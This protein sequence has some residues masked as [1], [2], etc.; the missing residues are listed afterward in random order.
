[1]ND[2][3][4]C[5]RDIPKEKWRYGLRSSAATGCGWIAVYNA[6]RLMGYNA[7]PERLIQHFENM[8]PLI[9]GNMGTF[10]LAPAIFFRSQG[11]GVK[12]TRSRKRFDETAQQADVCILCFWWREKL[13]I[14]SHFVALR[15]NGITFVGY[16]TYRGS[17]GPD[18]YGP[19]LDAFLKKRG[20][21]GATLIAINDRNK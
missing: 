15:H 14:G 10:V 16:N 4:Y 12:T 19:S 3:I 20:Y 13:K 6:L 5:Q 7:K 9:H 17:T 21:F 8:L 1:M 11:F 2:L 18:H